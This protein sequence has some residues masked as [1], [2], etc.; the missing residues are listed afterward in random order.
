M[1][2]TPYIANTDIH[3]HVNSSTGFPVIETLNAEFQSRKWLNPVERV[4]K[5]NQEHFVRIIFYKVRI[6][7]YENGILRKILTNGS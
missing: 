4:Q 7:F 3:G 1:T 2:V 6:S 5:K